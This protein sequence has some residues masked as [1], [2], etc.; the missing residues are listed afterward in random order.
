MRAATLSHATDKN[1]VLRY[2][3]EYLRDQH[4]PQGGADVYSTIVHNVIFDIPLAYDYLA[5]RLKVLLNT[6]A[7]MQEV[8]DNFR[9]C[10]FRVKLGVRFADHPA[11]GGK[12]ARV[13][14]R[15]LLLLHQAVDEVSMFICADGGAMHI[16]AGLGKPIIA[17]FGD[18]DP[19]RWRPWGVP[20]RV[21]QAATRNV[22]D[23]SV[24]EV[25]AAFH[26]LATECGF[27]GKIRTA[28][29][30]I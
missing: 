28:K 4:G 1:K 27:Q 15:R 26:E 25:L 23:L 5:R 6:L 14:C 24:E 19:I 29:I 20:H 18:S 11:F 17:L 2:S 16:A 8:T 3:F 13:S 7:S 21:L 9:T 12:K 10:S 22:A 30:E